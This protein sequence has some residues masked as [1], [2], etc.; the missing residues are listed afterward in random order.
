MNAK[1][2]KSENH[3]H[4][5]SEEGAGPTARSSGVFLS[6]ANGKLVKTTSATGP[7]FKSTII[8]QRTGRIIPSSSRKETA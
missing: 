5:P 3:L 7:R 8:D 2:P 1:S 6:L 4:R